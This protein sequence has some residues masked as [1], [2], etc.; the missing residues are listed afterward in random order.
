MTNTFRNNLLTIPFPCGL[1]ISSVTSDGKFLYALQPDRKTVYKLDVCGRILCTFKLNRKYIQIH[2]S[3]TNDIFYAVSDFDKTKIFLLNQC[4]NEI[5][6][7]EP[8]VNEGPC[9]CVQNSELLFVGGFGT[10][11]GSEQ[12]TIATKNESYA[13]DLS[14]NVLGKI[15][16]SGRNFNY[17]AIFENNGYLYEGLE[18]RYGP[19]NFVRATSIGMRNSKLQRLP[20]GFKVRSFFCYD[21]RLYAYVVKNGF[22]G[23][24][25]AVCT[26]FSDS[27]YAG[28][29]IYIPD[30]GNEDCLAE[31]CRNSC[32]PR[33]STSCSSSGCVSCS[34]VSS[35]QYDFCESSVQGTQTSNESCDI[36]E[37]CRIFNCLLN[38][39]GNKNTCSSR[40]CSCSSCG[41]NDDEFCSDVS[42][43]DCESL[44]CRKFKK[45]RCDL[46]PEFTGNCLP[47]PPCPSSAET[48]C[49]PCA[50]CDTSGNIVC[51]D[52]TLKVSYVGSEKCNNK[53]ICKNI[54]DNI[55]SD[56]F[57]AVKSVLK[58]KNISVYDEII[59]LLK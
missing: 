32:F 1:T 5:G 33:G 4:F 37:I 55:L 24:V 53:N 17:T 43:D 51:C 25:A 7:V 29:V 9:S 35:N 21:G 58:E 23:Y 46:N 52:P 11:S 54:K 18:S 45:C 47:L 13:A 36:D 31:S 2:F 40:G 16:S 10:C 12:L 8:D 39:C 34:G 20:Q 15:G 38:L 48:C 22:H 56:I 49:N 44:S 59:K 3:P 14:G 30:N 42:S 41:N 50:P 27:G 6:S 57:G 19:S 28:N 26:S